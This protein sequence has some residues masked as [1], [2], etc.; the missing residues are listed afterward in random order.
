MNTDPRDIVSTIAL[1]G[2]TPAQ[3]SLITWYVQA[4][5]G[6]GRGMAAEARRL[7]VNRAWV[8]DQAKRRGQQ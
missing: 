4:Q 7:G 6:W 3:Q 1:P 5:G 8:A 2:P